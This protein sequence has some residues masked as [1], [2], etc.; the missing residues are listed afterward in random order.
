[1]VAASAVVDAEALAAAGV[2]STGKASRVE[3][4]VR[5]MLT[6]YFKT[7]E[8]HELSKFLA[9]FAEGEDLTV[10]DN[11]EMYDWKGYVAFAERFF[12]QV[13]EIRFDQ[14]KCAVNPLSPTVAVATGVFRATGRMAS[15]EPLVVHNTYTLVLVKQGARWRIKHLH[16][17]SL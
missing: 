6:E 16:E 8:R 7:I 1:M 17:S 2:G 12:Q 14:E 10:F 11:K 5:Q 9:H 13:K 4:E 15:G 3:G